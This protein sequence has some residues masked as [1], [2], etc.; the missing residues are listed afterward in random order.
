MDPWIPITVAAAFMQNLRTALQKHLTGRLT[1]LG[2][3]YARFVMGVP[4]VAVYLWVVAAQTGQPVPTPDAAFALYAA[5]GGLAQILATFCLLSAF[6]YRNFAVGTA[7]SK[8]ETIQTALVAAVVLGEALSL[9]AVLGILVSLAGVL[10]ISAARSRLSAR[11]LL[12]GWAEK[13]ALIGLASGGLFGVSAVCYR[14]AALALDGGDSVI[15]AA[16]TLACV[17]VFQTAAMTL[18]LLLRDRGQLAAVFRHWRWTIVVGLTS[19]LG[20]AGWF[21]AM[22]MQNAALVRAV[23]QVELV[24]TFAAST[25]IFRERSSAAELAGIALVVGGILLV[26]LW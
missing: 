10:T 6:Q 4:F 9:G 18:W 17:L 14:A 12:T 19:M 3:T 2:A 26:L 5:L 11:T 23:G 7:Y 20:S 1:T 16:T 15:R 21:T 24:F 25:L 13:A 22:A 8:T